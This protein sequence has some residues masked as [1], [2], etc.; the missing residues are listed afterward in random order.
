MWCF[1]N[2]MYVK[3]E[4]LRISPFDHGYLYGLGVFETLR[5]Y[6]GKPFLWHEHFTSFLTLFIKIAK[7][8]F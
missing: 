5:T 4:D 3:A 1:H 8:Y 7:I 6:D 2:G